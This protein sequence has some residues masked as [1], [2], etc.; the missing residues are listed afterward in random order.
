MV[1]TSAIRMRKGK[2]LC[3]TCR[4]TK[5]GG[6]KRAKRGGYVPSG[7]P[8]PT[9]LERARVAA[10]LELFDAMAARH[11]AELGLPPMRHAVTP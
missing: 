2:R 8:T 9:E 5:P 10:E 11:R 1:M 6:I 3:A 4:A 7:K